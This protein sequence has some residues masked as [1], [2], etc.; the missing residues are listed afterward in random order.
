MVPM[1]FSPELTFQTIILTFTRSPSFP[2]WLFS[3]MTTSLARTYSQPSEVRMWTTKRERI[4]KPYPFIVWLVVT[5]EKGFCFYARVECACRLTTL[6]LIRKIC[7]FKQF[8][9]KSTL[10]LCWKFDVYGHKLITKSFG[11]IFM[12][13]FDLSAYDRVLGNIKSNLWIYLRLLLNSRKTFIVTQTFNSISLYF[14][15]IYIEIF[16]FIIPKNTPKWSYCYKTKL[17]YAQKFQF[18]SF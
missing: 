18:D 8:K 4:L 5:M 10:F 12:T 2:S 17:F 6:T 13:L 14:I 3:H 16:E 1:N 15:R 7:S 9:R 11:T